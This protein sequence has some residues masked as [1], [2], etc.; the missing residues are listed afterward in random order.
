MYFIYAKIGTQSKQR[1]YVHHRL[2]QFPKGK[3]I[4]FKRELDRPYESGIA[5]DINQDGVVFISLI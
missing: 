3:K 5:E 1:V 2:L 4:K